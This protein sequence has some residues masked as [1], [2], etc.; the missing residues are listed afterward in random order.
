MPEEMQAM[1]YCITENII[2]HMKVLHAGMLLHNND[3][4]T[5]GKLI[6]LMSCSEFQDLCYYKQYISVYVVSLSFSSIEYFLSA[7]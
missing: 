1:E 5:T 2:V 6:G 7:Q 3:G 4:L